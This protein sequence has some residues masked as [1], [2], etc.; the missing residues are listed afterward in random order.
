MRRQPRSGLKSNN[1]SSILFETQASK[2]IISLMLNYLFS[3]YKFVIA[4]KRNKHVN[5]HPDSLPGG[6]SI[7]TYVKCDYWYS[8]TLWLQGF[9]TIN[10]RRDCG[11]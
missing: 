7:T 1:L 8:T 5:L 6:I 2:L 10:H 9:L 3:I 11:Y 4:A